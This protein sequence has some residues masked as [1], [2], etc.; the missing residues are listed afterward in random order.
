MDQSSIDESTEDTNNFAEVDPKKLNER[1]P[2]E[3]ECGLSK[4]KSFQT[5]Y[6]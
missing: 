3:R 2:V 6:P 1:T 5:V 4:E